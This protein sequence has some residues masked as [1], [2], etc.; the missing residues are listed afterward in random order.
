MASEEGP[1]K[2][3]II[4]GSNTGVGFNA[5]V[6]LVR[7]HNFEVILACR[8]PEKGEAAVESI[9]QELPN[10]KVTYMQLDLASL[11]SVRKF[12]DDFHATGKPLHVLCDNGGFGN[13]NDDQAA[14]TEDGFELHMGTNHL[15]HFLLTMLLLDDLKKT[16]TETGEARIVVTASQ[17]HDPNTGMGKAKPPTI[18][19][20]NLMM[21]KEGTYNG[22]FAYSSSKLANVLFTKELARRLEGTGVTVNCLC[23]GFIPTTDFLRHASGFMRFLMNYPLGFIFRMRGI[24]S[25]VDDGGDNTVLLASDPNLK[26]TTGKYFRFLKETES[27]EESRNEEVAK[28]FWDVSADLVGYEDAKNL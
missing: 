4:T 26:G 12:A 23:P 8:T 14:K 22:A 16:A 6:K 3:C 2:V 20:D 28:R 7:N 19:F 18:D 11:K 27:S 21:E 10:A 15:G 25:T 5:A 17:L 13:F 24:T 9:K 1:Q